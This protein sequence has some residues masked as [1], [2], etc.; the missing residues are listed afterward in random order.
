MLEF[1]LLRLWYEQA[2]VDARRSIAG[3][4]HYM[5]ARRAGIKM[6]DAAAAASADDE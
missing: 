2:Y 5:Q 3:D 4:R 6:V 1:L